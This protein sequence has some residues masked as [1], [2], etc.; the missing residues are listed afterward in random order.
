MLT[1]GVSLLI[2]SALVGQGAR[3]SIRNVRDGGTLRVGLSNDIFGTVDPALAF[4]ALPG[5]CGSLFRPSDASPVRI[6]PEIAMRYRVSD[7]GARFVFILRRS[8]RLSNGERVK[9][10]NFEIALKRMLDPRIKELSYLGTLFRDIAGADAFVNGTTRTLSGV[11]AIGYKL[12]I[13]LAQAHPDLPERMSLV[14]AVP[15]NLPVDPEGGSAPLPSAGPYFASRY[16][17]GQELVLSRNR[18]Y[19]G[20]RR[21]HLSRI[22][23]RFDLP[24]DKL[25]PMVA[26]GKLDF[27]CNCPGGL[28][29]GYEPSQS[30]LTALKARYRL[31]KS[32]LWAKPQPWISYLAFNMRS[33]IF[34]NNPRLRRAVN[35]ALDRDRIHEALGSSF[36]NTPTDRYIP[37]GIQG[38]MTGHAYPPHRPKLVTAKRLAKGHTQTGKATLLW[39]GRS[40]APTP[41]AVGVIKS[42]LAAIGIDLDIKLLPSLADTAD[43]M[44]SASRW[45]LGRMGWAYDYPDPYNG[46]NLLFRGPEVGNPGQNNF[47]GMDLPRYNTLMDEAAALPPGP[48][49]WRAYARL[50]RGIM[51]KVA[52]IA[53]FRFVNA[54]TFVS[55]RVGCVALTPY[56]NLATACLK[57]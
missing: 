44:L 19:G 40:G 12:V 10:W 25:F 32:Q 55:S 22:S 15:R 31:N 37:W 9:A 45:D 26:S 41:A 33:G 38:R 3:A 56:L 42:N 27:T 50:E 34:H 49:R 36:A 11:R 5:T 54:V 21:V 46:I 57:G 20:H 18:F 7:G 53:V 35:F 39:Q 47:S 16:V 30:T 8:F 13:R 14:C 4:T 17:R 48:R 29:G 51:T 28:G 23:Y 52:P 6:V 24:G 2:A 43:E 1:I